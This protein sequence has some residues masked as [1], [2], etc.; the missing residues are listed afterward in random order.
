ME[1][2]N[3]TILQNM[4]KIPTVIFVILDTVT[5][6]LFE[7]FWFLKNLKRFNS[8]SK[9]QLNKFFIFLYIVAFT[10]SFSEALLGFIYPNS[11]YFSN[12][13]AIIECI[14]YLIIDFVLPFF[15]ICN[16]LKQIEEFS[17]EHYDISVK[18][19]G[20]IA[21]I[22]GLIYV[23]FAINNFEDRL[24]KKKQIDE[25]N[26]QK[27]WQNSSWLC[28]LFGFLG[29]HRFYT[30]YIEIGLFQ[31]FTFGGLGIWNLI[32]MLALAANKYKDSYGRELFNYERKTGVIL[33]LLLILHLFRIAVKYIHPFIIKYII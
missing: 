12:R 18:H 30:G 23:N 4:K 5:L 8:I 3:Y 19:N 6:G 22:L 14:F 21:F 7:F 29:I 28:F 32:D 20:F 2:K 16:L 15:L 17:K 13:N 11:P 27:S 1:K 26:S 24:Q 10:I 25:S 31:L 33:S 9:K